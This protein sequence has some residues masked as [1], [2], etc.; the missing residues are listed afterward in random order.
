MTELFWDTEAGGYFNNT[1]ADSS[2]LLRMKEGM[3]IVDLS[4]LL[5]HVKE[6]MSIVGLSILLEMNERCVLVS[7][8]DPQKIGRRV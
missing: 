2:I 3:S 8:P 1:S 4:I 6:G 7:E 5:L